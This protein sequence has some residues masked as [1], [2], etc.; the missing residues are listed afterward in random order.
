MEKLELNESTIDI[1]FCGMDND[2]LE[3]VTA[4]VEQGAIINPISGEIILNNTRTG[5]F[6][7]YF[8]DAND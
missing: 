5:I 7:D 6:T 3:Q 8:T 4:L 2:C 1:F